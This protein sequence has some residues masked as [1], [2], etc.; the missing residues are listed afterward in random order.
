MQNRNIVRKSSLF[1]FGI[2]V[3]MGVL[4][5]F[6]FQAGDR[7]QLLHTLDETITFT[8]Q[9]IN[10]YD[11]YQ[12]NDQVKSLVRLLDKTNALS[13][14]LAEWDS[15]DA[16][17]LDVFAEEQRLSGILILDE[18]LQVVSKTSADPESQALWSEL[19]SCSYV[20]DIVK[21]PKKTY[22]TQTI[23]GS[24]RYDFA[25]V[26]RKD[27][28]GLIVTYL[29]KDPKSEDYGDLFM[30][31]L[32]TDF[33]FEMNGVV[34]VCEDGQVVSS[35]RKNL[36]G[37]SA[38]SCRQL[39]SGDFAPDPDGIVQ[40][41]SDLS[42]WYG[43]KDATEHYQIYMFFPAS[44]VFLKRNMVTVI[45]CLVAV[46]IFLLHMLGR[47]RAERA[48]LAREQK[49][50]R[51]INA[52]GRIYSSIILIDLRAK[53][54][55]F[56]KSSGEANEV[57]GQNAMEKS[58]RESYIRGKI[59]EPY[60]EKYLEYVDMDTVA[61]RLEGKEFLSL[62]VQ[63]ADG[64]WMLSLL[65][66]HRYDKHGKIDAVL[67]VNRDVTAE[68]Q[69]EMAQDAA[70]R[71][72]LAAAEH[73][74]KAK[75]V[76]LNNMSHDIRTP[77]NAIIGFTALAV[78]HIDNQEHVLEY[79]KKIS[80]AGKHLL[81]LINDVLDM[82]RIENGSVKIEEA[83]V[84]LP[85]VLHDLRAIIQGNI[86]AKQQDLYID[87]QDVVHE[88][89]MTDKLRLNQVLLNIISNAV[90]FTPVG[91]MISL[92][93]TERPCQ[94]AGYA[95]YEFK[96]RDNG[97][98][99]DKEFQEHIFDSFTRE[100]SVTESGIQGTGLGLA[101]VKNIVD[102]MEGTI[103]LNSEKGKGSEFMVTLDCR[104]AAQTVEYEPIPELKGARALVVDDDANTCMSVCKMLRKI[105]MQADWTTSGK[106]AVMRAK[107]AW[108]ESCAFSA[109]I[110]DWMMPDM[111]GIETVR[112][113]RRVIG[114][115]TPI[116]I[117]TAYDWTDVEEEAREA[118]VTAFVAKPLF[119]SE[120]R[121]VLSTPVVS[122]K[123]VKKENEHRHAGRKILL[124]EDNELNR[125]IAETILQEVGIKVDSVTDGS[126]A[127]ERMACAGENQYDMILMDIQMP[128]MDGYTATREIRTLDNNRK[129]NIPIIAMT[130][131][132]FEE[133]RQK[134]FEAGMN[135][136]IAKPINLQVILQ[137]MDE[138]LK[139]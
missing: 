40:L 55:E 41:K 125:E 82:S 59:A 4:L 9:R 64:S 109:Y 135:G 92:R 100:Q 113:I 73:A 107:E 28:T 10:H 72:A 22:T 129:A 17:R 38:E 136:H 69:H 131:N 29:K 36:V 50:L 11:V 48:A 106:E 91:G 71:N 117:L 3:L 67:L 35:N 120:L 79:L 93:I 63:K 2:L 54:I 96:I 21:Y 84:H 103:T 86:G 16:K 68:K 108:E 111:N 95:T 112:R 99:I 105:E 83:Q 102:M 101:I 81:S 31:S 130:A 124:V 77:M 57:D 70:L 121:K 34:V 138:I 52:I 139:E 49:R 122:E 39:Y 60:Q 98:G 30:G 8:K 80:T 74:S 75:T 78:S 26:A 97:I 110:V 76:F 19:I 15:C 45:Y 133:D 20:S 5:F 6:F 126:D 43:R 134:A 123:D 118:G 87:T 37:Q 116:I 32:F 58:C 115:S 89:I 66:P 61:Q 12:T 127:V 53:K 46:S 7:G 27:E 132:A 14:S 65:I 23:I 24:D 119:L 90:K 47:S 94:R 18:D 13:S 128:R 137:T 51:I 56:I 62:T 42:T 114:E 44:Q 25:A 1:L 104:I 88:D 33:P 85:D